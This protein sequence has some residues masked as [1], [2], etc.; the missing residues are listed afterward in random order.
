MTILAT[1]GMRLDEVALLDWSQIKKK[2]GI[3]Y[4][5]VTNAIVKN[6]GS[7]R[8]VAIH[9]DIKFPERDTGRLFS[10]PAGQDGKAQNNAS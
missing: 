1:T 8:L 3:S 7:E 10:Y 2:S 4:F 5:D 6:D 9:V